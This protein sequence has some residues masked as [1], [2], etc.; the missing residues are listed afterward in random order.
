MSE[1]PVIL[2]TRSGCHLCDEAENLLRQFGLHPHCIDIDES[3]ELRARF[4]ACV[5]VVEIDGRLR[6]WGRINRVLLQR[7]LA[8]RRQG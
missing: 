8:R 3:A 5:P 1:H 2:Y 4:T 6:F 7:I